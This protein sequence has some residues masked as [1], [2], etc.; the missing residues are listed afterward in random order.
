MDV[1]MITSMSINI[2]S[3]ELLS[4]RSQAIFPFSAMVHRQPMA[5][6]CLFKTLWLTMLSST[7]RMEQSILVIGELVTFWRR[8]NRRIERVSPSPRPEGGASLA[9]GISR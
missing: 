6:R 2:R 4:V 9:S 8:V 1:A 3:N 7:M 5:S